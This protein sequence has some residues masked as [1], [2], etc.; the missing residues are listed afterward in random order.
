VSRDESRPTRL[1]VLAVGE[2]AGEVVTAEQPTDDEQDRC[3]AGSHR[4]DLGAEQAEDPSSSADRDICHEDACEDAAD[5]AEHD[6]DDLADTADAGLSESLPR[7]A[8][9]VCSDPPGTGGTLGSGGLGAEALR[10]LPEGLEG[11]LALGVTLG[12]CLVGG[13]VGVVELRENCLELLDTRLRSCLRLLE[14][15][16][17]RGGGAGLAG[18]GALLRSRRG[19]PGGRLGGGLLGG[20]R[21][22]SGTR[23]TLG[24]S[25]CGHDVPSS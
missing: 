3:H 20:G 23:S 15:S 19:R 6:Q 8:G 2:D 14:G 5:D 9:R 7:R 10:V 25:R 18:C 22:A 13:G 1:S 11:L 12:L 21:G 4:V 17:L 24:V 16:G